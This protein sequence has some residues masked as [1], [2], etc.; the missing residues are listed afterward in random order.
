MMKIKSAFATAQ[1]VGHTQLNLPCQD[2]IET[3]SYG[4]NL[5]MVLCDGAGSNPQSHIIA[6]EISEYF[7]YFFAINFEKIILLDEKGII[8]IIID[9]TKIICT[10]LGEEPD[11]TLLLVA[12]NLEGETVVI[13]LGDGYI[14]GV[15]EGKNRV[16]SFPE[17][18]VYEN[19][20]YFLS[21]TGA[22][23]H[24]RVIKGNSLFESCLLCSDGAG[25]S[26]VNKRT[27]EI[28]RAVPKM[29]DWLKA[30]DEKSVSQSLK[31]ALEELIRTKTT[32]DVSIGIIS[33]IR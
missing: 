2:I 23:S 24:I 3:Y 29:M 22:T 11:C 6:K 5:C 30:D 18:G 16:I 13:H 15:S 7:S 25:V 21:S 10:R 19:E 33:L 4:N 32:D 9:E 31:K 26:L 1:G 28:A 8:D 20:T 27:G 17:H 12:V 14:I